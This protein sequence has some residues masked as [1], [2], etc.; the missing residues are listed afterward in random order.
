VG[1]VV[2]TY[3]GAPILRRLP[4]LLFRRLVAVVLIAVGGLLLLGGAA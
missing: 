1:V 4:D 3:F 2:G